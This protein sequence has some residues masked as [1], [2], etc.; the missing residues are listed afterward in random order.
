MEQ[1]VNSFSQCQAFLDWH[2]KRTRVILGT[3]LWADRNLLKF[4]QAPKWGVGGGAG[5]ICAV[6]FALFHGPD[7]PDDQGLRHLEVASQSTSRSW[8]SIFTLC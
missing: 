1:I 2:L 6:N 7:F 8:I 5:V 4:G 3:W